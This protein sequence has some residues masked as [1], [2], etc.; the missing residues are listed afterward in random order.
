MHMLYTRKGM[1][2]MLITG[3]I[4][5]PAFYIILVFILGIGAHD[6]KDIVI[7]LTFLGTLIYH[8]S[9]IYFVPT[10]R[11]KYWYFVAVG[12]SM[13][14]AG[15]AAEFYYKGYVPENSAFMGFFGILSVLGIVLFIAGLG[16]WAVTLSR[17]ELD[18]LKQTALILQESEKT[19]HQFIDMISHQLKTPLTPVKGYSEML[20]DGTLG[21]LNPKQESAVNVI[22]E[23]VDQLDDLITKM[24]HISRLEAGKM[25]FTKCAVSVADVVKDV[26]SETQAFAKTKDVILLTS[27][28]EG[29]PPLFANRDAIISVLNNLVHNAI[30]FTPQ[31][32]KVVIE[33]H[34]NPQEIVVSVK[35]NGVGIADDKIAH[36][37]EKFHSV[38]PSTDGR[39]VGTGFGLSIC[40]G[41]VEAHGGKI[42]VESELGVGSKFFFSLPKDGIKAGAGTKCEPP[43][44]L[45]PVD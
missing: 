17:H 21:P 38:T 45:A 1:E 31:T 34:E 43:E 29:M 37:F 14:L 28:P 40:K 27:I 12:A 25:K 15:Y 6:A 16:T 4:I 30:K 22:H 20:K 42:W 41:I 13:V 26:L 35:D 7:F 19:R 32:G 9:A 39:V 10:S 18:R 5:V 11:N 3:A 33:A 8:M 44:V 2:T 36:L 24:L 23:S